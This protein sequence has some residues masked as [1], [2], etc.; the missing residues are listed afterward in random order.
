MPP[1]GTWARRVA[2]ARAGWAVL[3]ERDDD[4]YFAPLADLQLPAETE[5][6]LGLVHRQDGAEGA[7]AGGRPPARPRICSRHTRRSLRSGES[8]RC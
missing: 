3:I 4:A 2:K 6:Y 1:S 8:V 5:L 7:A